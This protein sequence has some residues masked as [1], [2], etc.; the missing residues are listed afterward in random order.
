MD[1]KQEFELLKEHVRKL[2]S[3]LEDP[4]FGLVTWCVFYGEHMKFIA[5]YWNNN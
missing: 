5:D 4:Q 1:A 3:L 2:N